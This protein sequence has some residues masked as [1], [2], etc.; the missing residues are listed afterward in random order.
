[1][2]KKI[3]KYEILEELGRGGM[4]V[5]YKAYDT[6]ME[7]EV[8]LKVI[9]EIGLEVPEIR[10]RFFREARTAGKLSH[11]NITIIHD[12]GEDDGRPFI[13]MEY[14]PGKDLR[15]ILDR[16]E[17][18]PLTQK[19]DIAVQTARGLAYSHSKDIIHRDVKPANI[20]I[21][22]ERKVKIMDF[23]IA[24]LSS[25]NLTSTGAVI[26]TPYYMSPEQ[27]QGKKIDRRSDIFSFGVLFY[28]LLTLH[29]PFSGEE[30]T[31][32]MYKIVHEEPE[33]LEEID[34]ACP[35]RLRDIVARTLRKN[36]DERYQSLDDVADDIESVLSDLR[37]GDRKKFDDQRKRLE[38]L[39]SES[40]TLLGK[41]KLKE[42][43]QVAAK[44]A[45]I[46]PNNSQV[47]R[48]L[49]EV[50]KA[51]DEERRRE[52]VATH[53]SV[54]SK[55]FT[56]NHYAAAVKAAENV[57]ALDPH[58]TDAL[59]FAKLSREKLAPH[60]IVN[61]KTL[62]NEGAFVETPTIIL[63][64]PAEISKPEPP[65]EPRKTRLYAIVAAV[66]LVC[67][68]VAVYRVFMYVPPTPSGYVALNILPWAEITRIQ[69]QA[70]GEIPLKEKSFTP[71][72]LSLP[73]GTYDIHLANPAY[74][75]PLVVTVTVKRDEIQAIRK[76]MPG[77]DHEK[78]LSFF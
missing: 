74:Q 43:Q 20:R 35:P 10:S 44:A 23:G 4:G 76:P 9:L 52:E 53:L 33:H 47:V 8:A 60:Q 39:L 12:V 24:K 46:D 50:K 75:K 48:V 18:L 42:A 56:A 61:D 49:Q 22:G 3:G 45:A 14:L 62:V 65:K 32:V 54:A 78:F 19:L 31:T 69:S 57:L 40:R 2:I 71:C 64:Q 72:R 13:V 5:V 34:L 67:V 37:S 68:A 77:F 1:M 25:S 41:R 70:A 63:P 55:H 21:V 15:S 30:P 28:E 58:N 11:D 73:E 6:L 38:K 27:I 26:G 7:R 17:P 51:E 29:K 16:R 59:R 66:L 36:P